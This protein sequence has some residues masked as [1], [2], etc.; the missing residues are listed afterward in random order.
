[1]KKLSQIEVEPL[2]EQRWSK[3]ERS[4]LSRLALETNDATKPLPE[5]RPRKVGGAWLLAA[6]LVGALGVGVLAARALPERA[7]IEQPSRVTTGALSSHLA[8]SG[9]SVDVEPQSAVV[10]GAETPQ[11]LLIVVDRGSIVCQVAPRP[12]DAPL[13]VQAGA[14]RV[15]V[16]GT[17]FSVTRLG[18]SARVKVQQGVVEVSSGGRNW[19]VRGGEVWPTDETAAAP[20]ELVHVPNVL[21]PTVAQ[22]VERGA[23]PPERPAA[24]AAKPR[25]AAEL[26][27]SEGTSTRTSSEV[28]S[29]S[30]QAVFE[31][32]TAL[33]R[34]DPQRASELYGTLEAGGDSWA[35]NALYARGRLQASRGNRVEARRLLERYLEQYPS[36]TNAE[37]ARAV[38]KRLR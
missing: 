15:R 35:Q 34:S 10:V 37:D 4:L 9:L 2:S 28:R 21:P 1:M 19:R 7:V 3:V 13:V 14:T 6:A 38:L 16:M 24:A 17:R 8:L 29:S 12:S 25:S 36:G 26:A 11:G 33:E 5:P 18:E 20:P 31:K 23:P 30:R 27:P 32:A 22:D